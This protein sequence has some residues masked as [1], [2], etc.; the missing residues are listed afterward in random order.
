MACTHTRELLTRANS[1]RLG[2]EEPVPYINT[3]VILMELAGLRQT[4]DLA[5]VRQYALEHFDALLLPDQDI[6]TALYGSR[7]K[8]IDSQLYNLS[9]RILAFYNASPLHPHH[10]LEWVRQNTV[11]IH[12]CGRNKPWKPGYVGILDVFYREL[13]EQQARLHPAD[14]R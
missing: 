11:I 8:L 6:L 14:H 12:Y 9:D 7:V 1:H 10:S 5:A 13:K 3:G 4:I 2:L